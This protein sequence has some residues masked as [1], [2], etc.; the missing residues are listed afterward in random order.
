[1]Q[2]CFYKGDFWYYLKTKNDLRDKPEWILV[3]G[4]YP[5]KYVDL[6]YVTV[7]VHYIVWNF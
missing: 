1:M 6:F 4:R 7:L 2:N 3:Y 5:L